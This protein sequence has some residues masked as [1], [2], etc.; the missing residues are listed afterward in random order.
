MRQVR[1]ASSADGDGRS[2]Y[3]GLKPV[4]WSPSSESALA[5]AEIEY[6]DIKSPTIFV[7]FRVKDGKGI[8]DTDTSFI[9]WTTTPWTIPANLAICL[10]KD[11]TY[12]LVDSEKGKFIVLEELVDQ[13]W[14]KF[15][16]QRKEI[17]GTYKGAQL[18]MITCQHPLYDRESLVILGDHVT[19]DAGT[20]CVHTAPGFGADDFFVC[21]KYGIDAYCNVDEHG[22]MMEDCGEWLAGQYVDDANKT[23]TMKLDELGCLLKMEWITHA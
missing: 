21:Q 20:G 10:N 18:E 4:Y 8:L 12:A 14:E 7:A 19:A 17:L 15:G 11:Y 6:H 3:K 5:E 23:V 9:I 16:L 2:H 22:C 1:S 13:L